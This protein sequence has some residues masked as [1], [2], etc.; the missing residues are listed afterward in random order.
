MGCPSCDGRPEGCMDC[1]DES[2]LDLRP[3]VVK[4]RIPSTANDPHVLKMKFEDLKK[5]LQQEINAHHATKAKLFVLERYVN[6]MRCLMGKAPVGQRHEDMDS[7]FN[8]T[9]DRKGRFLEY[10]E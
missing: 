10:A 9:A 6:D 8:E 1:I 3:A 7:H 5:T 4:V 2:K